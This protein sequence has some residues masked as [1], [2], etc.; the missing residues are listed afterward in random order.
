MSKLGAELTQWRSCGIF[1][2]YSNH[3]PMSADEWCKRYEATLA[4]DWAKRKDN[5]PNQELIYER[6][7]NWFEI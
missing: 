1:F 5:I 6:N 4:L 7:G 3:Y 2:L